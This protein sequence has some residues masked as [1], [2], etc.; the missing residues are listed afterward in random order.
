MSNTWRYIKGSES[1]FQGAPD[2]ATVRL[3][4]RTGSVS[5]PIF[6]DSFVNG[7]TRT[8]TMKGNYDS[9]IYCLES[10]TIIA[11]RERVPAPQWRYIKGSEADFIGAPNWSMVAVRFKDDDKL[12]F[13]ESYDED[14]RIWYADKGFE[15]AINNLEHW[16]LIAQ[17]ERVT[18]SDDVP[19]LCKAAVATLERKG[20]TWC[21]GAEWKPPLGKPPAYITDTTQSL[22]AERGERYGKFAEGAAIMQQLKQV[23][24]ATPGWSRLSDSQ[25][26]AL[27]MIT[28]KIGRML[29]GDP[30]YDDN[31]KD[32]AGYATLV[33]DELN[34]VKR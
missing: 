29:N 25:K 20:Y 22:I 4:P 15:T 26:E 31:W 24:H 2:S 7:S 10:W 12:D 5:Y 32:I 3:V 17:R 30:N 16:T 8:D 34:G 19:A 11:Q 6:A 21:G 9:V 13:A 28:H 14:S 18:E 27:D 33:A 1:D 23:T